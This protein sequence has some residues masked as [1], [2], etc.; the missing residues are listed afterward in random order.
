MSTHPLDKLRG[1]TAS[2]T[3]HPQRLQALGEL[4]QD[5]KQDVW[6]TLRGRS[7]MPGIRPGTRL[8]L[9]CDD[10]TPQVGEVIAFRRESHLV[11]HRLQSVDEQ[12]QLICQGDANAFQ[13]AP[14]S[15]SVVLGVVVEAQPP[16][17]WICALQEV[18][19]AARGLRDAARHLRSSRSIKEGGSS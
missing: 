19:N 8:R 3:G 9:R 13:D 12:G 7:M 16:S 6:V 2:L 11:V 14:I 10:Q 17:R 5:A 4:W 18:V 1:Q 15:R